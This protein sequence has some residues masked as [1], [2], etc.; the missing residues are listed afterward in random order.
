MNWKFS[1]KVIEIK[2]SNHRLLSWN[3]ISRSCYSCSRTVKSRAIKV[4]FEPKAGITFNTHILKQALFA[5]IG[6]G[7]VVLRNKASQIINVGKR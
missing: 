7:I 5:L 3:C 6:I 1:R 4:S 2:K